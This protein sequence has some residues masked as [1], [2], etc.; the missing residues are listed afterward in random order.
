MVPTRRP[1]PK[2]LVGC[3][4]AP[5][6]RLEYYADTPRPPH[7]KGTSSGR[8]TTTTENRTPK[9]ASTVTSPAQLSQ[10]RKR[11]QP[12]TKHRRH[13]QQSRPLRGTI[14]NLAP[15]TRPPRTPPTPALAGS[16]PPRPHLTGAAAHT[17]HATPTATAATPPAQSV[18]NEPTVGVV[19][20][21][22][23]DAPA[24]DDD[25][26]RPRAPATA[27]VAATKAERRGGMARSQNLVACSPSQTKKRV[28]APVADG[29]RVSWGGGG[30]LG[31]R[32]RWGGTAA[33]GRRG[34]E[35]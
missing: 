27:A 4:S 29:R 2:R 5:N 14:S 23:R 3:R 30:Q 35:G 13:R 21:R 31:R 24:N 16:T 15:L 34:I 12:L 9:K 20:D 28:H 33:R 1:P 26:A 11:S 22:A 25:D 10:R 17:S 32:Q 19:D 7:Q 18:A 8:K 6:G